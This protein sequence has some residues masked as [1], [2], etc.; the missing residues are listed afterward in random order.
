MTLASLI[1]TMPMQRNE[2]SRERDVGLKPCPIC[3]SP[4]SFAE[5]PFCS[6]RCADVDLHRWLGGLY[7]VPA[8]RVGEDA[9]SDEE[10]ASEHPDQ[11]RIN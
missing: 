4:P 7:A 8:E 1:R 6:R 10:N 11:N 2:K 3:G 5:R 9:A